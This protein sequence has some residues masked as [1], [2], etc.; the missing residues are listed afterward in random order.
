MVV[1]DDGSPTSVDVDVVESSD[2]VE[3][4]DVVGVVVVVDVLDVVDEVDV[5]SPTSVEVVEVESA[6]VVGPGSSSGGAVDV[7]GAGCVVVDAGAVAGSARSGVRASWC[8]ATAAVVSTDE[9]DD[10]EVAAAALDGTPT[11]HRYQHAQPGHHGDGG[12]DR[13]RVTRRAG[14][15]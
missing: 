14:Y 15:G 6:D 2:V 4:V 12:D 5:G 11:S 13:H 7:V 9:T 1:D 8:G 3:L 10:A